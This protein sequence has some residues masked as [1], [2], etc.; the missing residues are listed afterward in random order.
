MDRDFRTYRIDRFAEIDAEAI[1]R[2]RNPL[3]KSSDRPTGTEMFAVAKP[4]LERV[5]DHSREDKF[6]EAMATGKYQPELLFPQRPD[7]VE[8]IRRHPA[9]V[10]KAES[11]ARH[12]ARKRS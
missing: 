4:I 12:V 7:V 11:V 1:K 5:L 3:L 9:L 6:L 8:R 2:L 10:W